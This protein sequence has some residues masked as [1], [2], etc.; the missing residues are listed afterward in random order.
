MGN[1]PK[2]QIRRYIENPIN[3]S[4]VTNF[5]IISKNAIVRII[6]SKAKGSGFF[7]KIPYPNDEHNLKVLITVN[8]V[9]NKEYL[10]SSNAIHLEI[11][12]ENKYF[13]LGC[14]R[15]IWTNE[16]LDYTIIEI[17]ESDNIGFF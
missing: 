2:N 13:C 14:K 3:V 8:H 17:I 4:A 9:L 1:N 7:C 12:K 16:E 5:G 6:T 10:E 15:K 11:N